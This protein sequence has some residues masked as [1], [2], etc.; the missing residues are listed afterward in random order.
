MGNSGGG[1]KLYTD[2]E[3]YP[4]YQ[5]GFIWDFIDQAIYKPLPNGSEFLSY[6][7]DWHDRP[8]DYEFCGNGI[9]FA[10]RTL[11]PKLQTVKHLYSNIK[12][13]V[14]EKSVTIKNDN[15]FEDLSAYTFL[16]RV[17]EDGRKVSESEY[18]FDVKPG[19]EATF[20]VEFAVGASNA[21]RIY[22]VACVQNEATEWAPKGHEIVRGL[23]VA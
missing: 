13:A 10:D 12:I 23:Y 1:L 22:E 5:G 7:G 3:K 8:S 2:L 6:G 11:T 20:P 14:D 17:Y 19:E 9:V 4:E 21:E 16:A 18:H 15:L